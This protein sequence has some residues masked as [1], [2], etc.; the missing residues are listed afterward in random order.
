M[1][2][3]KH[4]LW[5]LLIE[6]SIRMPLYQ[7]DYVQGR[8]DDPDAELI[9]REFVFDLIQAVTN[10][11]DDIKELHFIF[12]GKD[13]TAP[14]AFVPVD[15]QQR[16]TILF[17]LHWY[18]FLRAVG[19]DEADKNVLKR[20][21][22]ASRDTSERFCERLIDLLD[23]DDAVEYVVNCNTDSPV[24][25]YIG[26][27]T[28]FSG[29]I[30]SDP[31]VASMLVVADE[32]HKQ[33]SA[34]GEELM[35]NDLKEKLKSESCPIVFLCLDM[36]Q[37]L[38]TQH[39]I[40]DLYIKMNSRGK[41]LTDFENYK[42][43]LKKRVVNPKEIDLL[44]LFFKNFE[45][46]IVSM[47][48]DPDEFGLIELCKDDDGMSDSEASR[49]CLLGRFNNEY[50]DFFFRIVDDGNIIDH[51]CED[52]ESNEEQCFDRAMMSFVNEMIRMEFMEFFY[53]V[54]PQKNLLNQ[55][56]NDNK[57]I[58]GMSGKEFY[59]FVTVGVQE[60]A[61]KYGA[62][63]YI[64]EIPGIISRGF[65]N[66]IAL[67][68]RLV[69]RDNDTLD[70]NIELISSIGGDERNYRFNDVIKGFAADKT[71]YQTVVSQVFFAFVIRFGV[72]SLNGEMFGYLSHLLWRCLENTEFEH[73]D[74]ACRVSCIF[75]QIVRNVSTDGD[76]N[77]LLK[78]IAEHDSVFAALEYH[79]SEERI[80]AEL[81]LCDKAV[82]E[83]LL[84]RAH[85]FHRTA[86]IGYLLELSKTESG[87]DPD[88][89]ERYFIFI[90]NLFEYRN[91]SLIVKGGDE[92]RK[93]F[94]NLL[95]LTSDENGGYYHLLKKP[96]GKQMEFSYE[97]YS[98]LLSD[99]L[100]DWTEHKSL[101][102][103]IRLL[104][105]SNESS[106]LCALDVEYR[107]A[108]D[109]YTD[110]DW[111]EC[112]LN[113]DINLYALTFNDSVS[114]S[115]AIY[116]DKDYCMLYKRGVQINTDSSELYTAMIYALLNKKGFIYLSSV[117]P[118]MVK[119]D[120]LPARHI[121]IDEHQ[122]YYKDGS[123]YVF[124]EKTPQSADDIVKRFK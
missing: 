55:Y 123:F 99:R 66:A 56:R 49:N 103:L 88:L 104:F 105:A 73:F 118:H 3:N 107:N 82:W 6:K 23:D 110:N 122:I 75:K 117:L 31:T 39:E 4:T 89:F 10:N 64:N 41:L 37:V 20:F 35:W 87:Y 76:L 68:E 78:I 77:D 8:K 81:L 124:G 29:N 18:V 27:R 30:A 34:L 14:D 57:S 67:L 106:P 97:N 116:R 50:T 84:E 72:E 94:E 53:S 46:Y 95:L 80:K 119:D 59:Y 16:L 11:S 60:M 96:N 21:Q 65:N 42:A 58:V 51:S 32:I 36:D 74:D 45:N 48:I 79:F 40:R 70:S 98:R 121:E 102:D 85:N 113:E 52:T 115:T 7:R 5:S 25:D 108:L 9:R 111:R 62:D 114:S 90:T 44:S 12:G 83:P 69:G 28:W 61:L 13:I 22:Y 86:Q 33:F 101:L 43:Y 71:D 2:A 63:E 100:G 26:K 17:L 54:K 38:G 120:E 91:G 24:A 92:C 112:F 1:N 47:G 15:G 93:N 109:D 19:C